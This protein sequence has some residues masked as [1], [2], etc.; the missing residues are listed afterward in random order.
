MAGGRA[1]GY[2]RRDCAFSPAEKKLVVA[3]V[4]TVLLSFA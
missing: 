4:G 3:G 2:N 1:G